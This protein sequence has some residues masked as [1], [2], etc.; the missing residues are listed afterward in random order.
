[1]ATEKAPSKKKA[2]IF[3][4]ALAQYG[5]VTRAADEAGWN[6]CLYRKRQADPAFARAWDEAAAIGVAALEDEARRR[7]YE[8]WDEPVWH[9]GEEC[10]TVRKFSDT[11]L[12]VLLKAHMPE[13]Y[14][15]RQK[16]EHSGS[17][18]LVTAITEG[19]KRSGERS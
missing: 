19:R 8:G 1:M 10:G 5:N 12:I 18:D 17:M 9:K 13:K 4:S 7:A 11:L 6:R 14:Q 3:L 2:E 16:V 15:E